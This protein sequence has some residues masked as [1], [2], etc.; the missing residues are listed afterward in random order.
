MLRKHNVPS[1]KHVKVLSEIALEK[2]KIGLERKSNKY[3]KNY[4]KKHC[5]P[6]TILSKHVMEEF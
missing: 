5:Q 4:Y 1:R 2:R 6:K 3:K